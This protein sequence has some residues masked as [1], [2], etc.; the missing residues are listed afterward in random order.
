M[1][2]AILG[3]ET[4]LSLAELATIDAGL[5]Q[6][7]RDV[8]SFDSDKQ[9]FFELGGV[10]KVAEVV[11]ETDRQA[12]LP[13]DEIA[14]LLR[15]ERFAK[16]KSVGL[17]IYADNFGRKQYQQATLQL[18]KLLKP[19][20]STRIVLPSS[21]INLNAAGTIHNRLLDKGIELL[22]V[23]T[24]Q[25][26]YVAEVVWVQ[27]IESY[28]HRDWD[29]PARDM[30]IG[31]V[32][33]KLAQSLINL[34]HPDRNTTIIDPFCGPGTILAEALLMGHQ[35]KGFDLD[36]KAIAAAEAN[37]GWLCQQYQLPKLYELTQADAT[38]LTIEPG[39][40]CIV[41]EGYLGPIKVAARNSSEFESNYK[42]ID[43][44]YD[45]F[46]R[47]LAN[48]SHNKPQNIIICLPEW[49]FGKNVVSL[50]VIDQI[51]K[52]G[53]TIQRFAPNNQ[54]SLLYHRSD[55]VVA[56]RIFSLTI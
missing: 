20:R 56:R 42:K 26:W 12:D 54:A 49:H 31:M 41:T 22:C 29:R 17:S 11:L 46:L 3:R 36:N 16:R 4:E 24:Q 43:H 14:A 37:L 21:G 15:E 48:Q 44:L 13:I 2:L 34:S 53:Y 30:R 45:E 35:V 7:S 32:P 33:P 39:D 28:S 10:S 6:I 23:V 19:D 55:Q 27:D 47:N 25:R 52:I 38:T 1:K 9:S 5:K 18:K 40:Y 8:A 50:Q 51:A